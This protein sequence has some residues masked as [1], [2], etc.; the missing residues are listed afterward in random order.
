MLIFKVL[1]TAVRRL[2]YNWKMIQIFF[3]FYTYIK[4]TVNNS[5][6]SACG[7]KQ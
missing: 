2:I 4:N 3:T 7:K 6:L 1:W 5:V